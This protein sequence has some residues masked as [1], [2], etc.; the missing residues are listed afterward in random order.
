MTSRLEAISKHSCLIGVKI[1]H[2]RMGLTAQEL[3]FIYYQLDNYERP[4]GFRRK[5]V[6][7]VNKRSR[8][9]GITHFREN[10]CE[11]IK[12]NTGLDIPYGSTVSATFYEKIA[13]YLGI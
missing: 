6:R 9:E 3:G 13:D 8:P 7:P 10:M 2:R 12:S 1:S 5:G 4:E 11:Y